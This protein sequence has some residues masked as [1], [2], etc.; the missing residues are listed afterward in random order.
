MYKPTNK[1]FTFLCFITSITMYSQYTET[2]NSNRPGESQ[3]AFSVGTQ[4]I[5]AESSID[6]GNDTHSLL[7]T[8]IDIAAFNLDLRY[9]FWK[10]TLEV[11][12]F[13][14]FRNET[15]NFTT[16]NTNPNKNTGIENL[17]VGAKYLFYDPYKKGED[18]PNLYSYHANFRFKWKTLLPAISIYAGA[19]FDL[20]NELTIGREQGISPNI[21]LITQNNWG[22]WVWVNNIIA[23][24]VS[25]DFPSYSWITTMTHSLSPKVAAFVE[26]Q[27]IA[28]DL[29]ADNL[30]RGGGAYLITN[31]LQVDISGFTNFKDTPSRWNAAIG[32]SWR[33]DLHKEEK[34][35]EDTSKGKKDKSNSK[36]QGDKKKK[37]RRDG[38][39]PDGG[40]NGE[41]L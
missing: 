20:E 29:Y 10:E 27:L 18:K 1:L 36:K 11:S 17:Q 33:L 19:V 24:R 4:V 9:G 39:E 31:N 13:F 12:S 37:K 14:R 32:I 3:G 25:S 8:D 23:D 28:G 38:I 30:I 35:I 2:I 6:F 5:Q 22:R 16:G 15:V 41:K 7:D 34:I 40:N 21:A 26:Y